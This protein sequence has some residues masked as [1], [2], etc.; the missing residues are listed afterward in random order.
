VT[1]RVQYTLP[2]THYQA[3]SFIFTLPT[4]SHD[5]SRFAQGVIAPSSGQLTPF[6]VAIG[7]K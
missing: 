7:Q 5:A 3:L 6:T 2:G 4:P 1:F